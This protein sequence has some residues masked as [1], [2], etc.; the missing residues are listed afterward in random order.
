[1]GEEV[2]RGLCR[3]AAFPSTSLLCSI[4]IVVSFA[5][6]SPD[7]DQ[8]LY[9]LHSHHC[10]HATAPANRVYR[11]DLVFVFAFFFSIYSRFAPIPDKYYHILNIYLSKHGIKPYFSERSGAGLCLSESE[12]SK[13]ELARDPA[14]RTGCGSAGVASASRSFC[15]P[16]RW[17]CA[18]QR[19]SMTTRLP[20][21]KQE[22]TSVATLF[23]TCSN[24]PVSPS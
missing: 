9:C 21:K 22:R 12:S 15:A 18:F 24:G 8:R 17:T 20:D 11:M 6:Q 19:V 7:K 4:V 14:A 1:M 2:E 23:V 10:T 5:S 3:V 13:N 16:C